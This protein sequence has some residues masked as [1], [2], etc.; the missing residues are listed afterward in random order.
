MFHVLFLMVIMHFSSVISISH[1]V[2]MSLIKVLYKLCGAVKTLFIWTCDSATWHHRLLLRL[3][4]MVIAWTCLGFVVSRVSLTKELDL[5]SYLFLQINVL[6]RYEKFNHCNV[7]FFP[8]DIK[9][10]STIWFCSYGK[11]SYQRCIEPFWT[12]KMHLFAKIFNS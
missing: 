6:K 3:Q 11:D 9:L 10:A 4:N 1:G 8:L 12:S 5:Y 7:A 2:T